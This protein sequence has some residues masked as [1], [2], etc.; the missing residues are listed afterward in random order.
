[1]QEVLVFAGTSEGRN[2]ARQLAQNEILVTVCVAT[3]YGREV[4]EE[5]MDSRI[6]VRIGRLTKVQMEELLLS[7]SWWAVVDATHPFAVEV[8]KNIA[9]ACEKQK[10]KYLRLLREDDSFGRISKYREGTVIYVESV[11]EAVKYLNQS[12]G[13]ILL[14]TGSKDL[15][16]YVQGI[17]DISRLYVRIL[18]NGPEVENCHNLGLK[19][20]QII[21]MQ[22][23]FSTALNVALLEEFQV[24]VLVTKETASAGGFP[25]KLE[26]AAQTGVQTVVI[27]RPK[28]EGVSLE[29]ILGYFGVK[30]EK[31]IGQRK[32]TLAGIGMGAL[33]SMTREVYE[34]CEKA[35]LI[36]GAARMLDT[37]KELSKPM[38]N[39]YQSQ[40]IL[41]YVETHPQYQNIVVLLSGD[42]GFYS[43]AKKLQETLEGV[44]SLRI[45]CGVP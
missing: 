14:T 19:G 24:S 39:L 20:R 25:Q 10:K 1:M 21:C 2:L 32:I 9:Q 13:N 31:Y 5:E 45:L 4:L 34:E 41:D 29:E 15:S 44:C 3:Q 42:V 40:E 12:Q 35:D 6:Q 37:I 38:Q 18:P 16:L 17:Q 8:S 11:L 36:L 33:S 43:G 7:R 27:R 22:G 26:A 23:P 30:K 28:E